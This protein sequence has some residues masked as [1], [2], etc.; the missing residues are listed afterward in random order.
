MLS[1]KIAGAHQHQNQYKKYAT[2][3]S[4][5]D[6]KERHTAQHQ[7]FRHTHCRCRVTVAYR[8]VL[9]KPVAERQT[10]RTTTSGYCVDVNLQKK[11]K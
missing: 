7:A 4:V 3:H 11:F 1:K 2:L 8:F 10:H 5:K 9:N 6:K